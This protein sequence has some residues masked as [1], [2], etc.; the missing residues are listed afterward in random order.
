[1][2]IGIVCYPSVGGSGVVATEL[3]KALAERGH[4]IHLFHQVCPFV[5]GKYMQ[6]FLSSS[7]SEPILCFQ[8]P[9]YEIQLASKIAEVASREHLDIVHAHYA[10]PH[11]ICAYMGRKWLN[12]SLKL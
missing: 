6:I 10:I 2:K 4:E 3:G 9:P 11:A 8:Y 12:E 7:G 1:M 5:Y